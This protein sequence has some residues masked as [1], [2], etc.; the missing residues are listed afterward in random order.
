MAALQEPVG[1]APAMLPPSRISLGAS[2]L[3]GATGLLVLGV[4][5]LLYGGYVHEGRIGE[6]SL[7]LLA[8][9]EIA[10]I[11]LGS[12][13][14]IALL[15]RVPA[16][17]VAFAGLFITIA[18]NLM[19]A[20]MPLFLARAVSGAGGGL[21]VGVAAGAIARSKGLNAAAAAFLFLQAAS[22]YAILQWFASAATPGSASDVQTALAVIAA[23]G[24]LA[25]PLVPAGLVPAVDHEPGTGKGAM[26]LSGWIGLAASALLVG[27][28][29]G[30]WAY[31]G[32]WLEAR[33]IAPERIAP[34]LTAS[35]VGQMAGALVAITIGERG[36]AGARAGATGVALIAIVALLLLRGA[37]GL[38]G[39]S[40]VVG[41]GFVWMVLTPA[42]TG[43]LLE[44]DPT[45]RSL[46]FAASAQLMGAATL[47]TVAGW[48][49]GLA[50]IDTVLIACS[51]AVILGLVLIGAALAARPPLQPG[52]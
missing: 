9:I 30:I 33:G 45:R 51:A 1:S 7:G 21:L 26:P 42:L 38:A 19:P 48:L 34:M 31:M 49:I 35:M 23:L 10:A 11:A 43:F 46:P 5:P 39:W 29:V 36:H 41:Y 40:L 28:V 17:A 18:A 50:G 8:A 13:G 47:P 22:Q 27:A 12:A 14:G 37:E 3:I 25:L 6:P 4:Q 52:V 15:G 44:A 24:V 32:L 20:A 16:R 2:L